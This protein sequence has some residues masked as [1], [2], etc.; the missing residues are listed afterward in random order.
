MKEKNF[1]RNICFTFF[2]DYRLSAK[3]IEADFGKEV[4]AD[5]YNAIID[6]ALYGNEP[7]LKGVLKYTWHT[8]KSTIDR[9]IERRANGF[10]RENTVQTDVVK[11]YKE[12]HPNATQREISKATG[13][14]TGKVNKVLKNINGSS[15]S[16]TNS[17]TN[18]Y[19]NSSSE[20]EH[21]QSSYS[22]SL[23]T[24]SDKSS[25]DAA[26]L[27][28]DNKK[29]VIACH[30][31]GMSYKKETP[32]IQ[33]ET[34]LSG[35]QIHF[36]ITEYEKEQKELKEQEAE[37]IKGIEIPLIDGTPSGTYTGDFRID[38]DDLP[39]LY[40]QMAGFGTYYRFDKKFVDKWL[41]DDYGYI[42][43]EK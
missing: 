33:S 41:Y 9:S 21:E 25:S 37:R 17:D 4:V 31:K 6:Y 11:K 20:R 28:E 29:K 30:L 15:N 26:S 8:T 18:S 43:E 14:S 7:E 10:S 16:N 34:G 35:K 42:H 24:D 40:K 2:E 3:E 38:P 23:K 32:E 27:Q 19:S 13:V 22:S 5:Y 36:I 39:S 1:K 12:E